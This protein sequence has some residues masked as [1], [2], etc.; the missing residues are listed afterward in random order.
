MTV[1]ADKK[2]SSGEI[3]LKD[4]ILKIRDWKDYLFSK[5]KTIVLAGVIGGILGLTYA[6]LKRPVYTAQLNFALQD[7]SQ[8][9]SGGGLGSA[10][11][12]ASQFGINLGGSAGGAFSGDNLMELM[13]S[14]YVIEKTLLTDVVVNGKMQSLAD[15]YIDFNHIRDQWKKVGPPLADMHFPSTS[16]RTKFTRQQDSVL[17]SFY[18]V[19]ND[20]MLT[21][22]KLDKKLSIITVKFESKNELF[23]KY[24]AE[25]LVKTVSDYYVASK[26]AKSA[27]N[28][29]ILQKQTDSVRRELNS[30]ITGVASSADVNPNPNP[31]LQIIRV[32]A[33][34]RQVDVQANQAI[35]TQLVA[36]LELAKI[37]LRRETP[38]IQVIDG[39]VLPLEK[40]Q[41]GKVVGFLIGGIIF[42]FFTVLFLLFK[43]IG[44]EILE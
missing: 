11:G 17:G 25:K 26:T 22:D 8:N 3:T 23:S 9:S 2:E 1:S 28:V 31:A 20:K 12:L 30:A 13:K 44:K 14:R 36:N 38:L 42:S 16:D 27:Q 15:F 18:N 41:I 24:F 35:L 19:I 4:V 37:T 21:V 43:R 40:R 32:P 33:L 29:S 7:D 6:Y 34:H 39:P 5:W 10:L